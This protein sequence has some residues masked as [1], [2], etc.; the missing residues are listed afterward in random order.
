MEHACLVAAMSFII[1][2][3]F[4]STAIIVP[5]PFSGSRRGR[6]KI[7]TEIREES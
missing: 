5:S 2:D 7:R 3:L 6:D 4:H 1:K